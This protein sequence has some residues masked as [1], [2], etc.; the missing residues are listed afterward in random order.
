MTSVVGELKADRRSRAR[1]ERANRERSEIRARI[2][3]AARET[4]REGTMF[5]LTMQRLAANVGLSRQTIYRYFPTVQ[6]I[7]RALS[8][9][10][11]SEIYADLPDLSLSDPNFVPA[12]VDVALSVFC[13]DSEVVRVLVLASAIGRATGDWVQVDPEEVLSSA[14]ST[15]PAE[16]RRVSRDPD[17]AARVLVTYFRG[18]LY[19]WAA[20]FLSDA[21][22]AQEV[23]K[24]GSLT[25]A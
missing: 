7:F 22:F 6:E 9:E 21:E 8:D 13:A 23:R 18:A 24:A 17:V 14:L 15:V 19:G 11:I 10:V 3:D 2:L 1:R 16:H 25:V 4:L 5:D 20:G 12:F